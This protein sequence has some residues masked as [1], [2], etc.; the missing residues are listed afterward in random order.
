MKC[1]KCKEKETIATTTTYFTQLGNCYVIIEHVPCMQCEQCGEK[2]FATTVMER[3]ECILDK[4]E[5][6]GEA[7]LIMDYDTAA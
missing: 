2:F 5:K 3:I 1:M 4:L 6:K 7:V